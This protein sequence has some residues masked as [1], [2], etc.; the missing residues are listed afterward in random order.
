MAEPVIVPVQLEVT[1]LDM[2]NFNPKDVQKSISNA[3]SGVKKSIQDAFKGIDPS[4]INKPIESAMTS[5]SKSVQTAEEAYAR[6]NRTLVQAGKSTT[7]YKA[8]VGKI[9]SDISVWAKELSHVREHYDLTMRKIEATSDS[10]EKRRLVDIS[11]NDEATI[12]RIQGHISKLNAEITKIN[13]VDFVK[14]ADATQLEKVALAYQKVLSVTGEVNKKSGDFNQTV[15]DNQASDKYAEL[16]KQAE[17]YQQKLK[18]LSEKSKEMEFKGATDNQWENLRKETE[19][20]SK[21][22]DDVLKKMDKAIK[23]GE[24]FRFGEGSKKDLRNQYNS[25]AMSNRN[26]KYAKERSQNNQSPYT[27][28]YQKA[29]DD[30]DKLEQKVKSIKEKS[31]KMIELG[32]SKKEFASTAYD[33]NKLK[34]EVEAA[35]TRITDMVNEGK[36]FRFGKGDAA[37]EIN[38]VSQKSQGLEKELEDVASDSEKARR[39]LLKFKEA[40]PV[41]SKILKVAGGIGYGFA[42]VGQGV[43]TA[44]LALGK[45]VKNM[46][47][48][49]KAG[50]RT[51]GDLGKKF[52]KLSRNIMMFGLGFR[53]AYYAVK[54]LRNIFVEGFKAMGEQFGEIGTPMTAMMESFD[55]LKGSLATVLQPIA[56]ILMPLI[57]TLMNS[58]TGVMEKIAEFTAVLSGQ[59]YIYK[60]VAKDINSV[61]DA[62]KNANKQL[63][64]Y[65]KLEV[66]SDNKSGQE[67][68]QMAVGDA[69]TASSNFAKMVK[70]AWEKADFTSV[71]A[72]I[73]KKLAEVLNSAA[74]NMVPK[75]MEFANKILTSIN[76]F[77]LG[78]DATSVGSA[79]SNILNA[80][81]TGLDWSQL[82]SLF[83][84]WTNTVWGFLDGLVNGINWSVLGQSIN[85]GL[86]S[87]VD[88]LDFD[89]IADT[90]SGLVMGLIDVI[91]SIDWNYIANKLFTGV[92]KILGTVG[93]KM[94]TSNNPMVS[95][96]GGVVLALGEAFNNLKP[97]IETIIQAFGPIITAILPVISA[98][99]P[100]ISAIIGTLVTDLLPPIV[101]LIEAVMPLLVNIIEIIM[102]VIQREM[103]KITSVIGIVIDIITVLVGAINLV[104][105]TANVLTKVF[106]GEF[107]SFKDIWDALLDAWRPAINSILA[108]VEGMVNGVITALNKMIGGLNKVSFDI[109]DWGIFGD[110]AG[111][112]FGLNIGTI[113]K[114][115]I[116][117][118]AQGA[119]IP[120]NQEFLAVLGDQK[121]G[122]NIEAPLDTIKQA[123][124]EVLAETRGDSKDPIVL[125]LNG[126]DIAKVVWDEEEKRYKQTGRYATI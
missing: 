1:D 125:R 98:L 59:K 53:T 26:S 90:I 67:Y 2:S 65:D 6:Y 87:L 106:R 49:G 34:S 12:Q 35:K 7:E 105:G 63:A 43:G 48:F 80:V 4:A 41:L 116:P 47:L 62:S 123:L 31:A 75:A 103:S 23:S 92:M 122:T 50:S 51:S 85:T 74:T 28:D 55:R 30:L 36:A 45:G 17:G 115:S 100:P 27:A 113:G 54:R 32:A 33:A 99:L 10:T 64:S 18:D 3:L 95:A 114:V 84:N 71:G 61:A 72:F 58:L 117:R 16:V 24:A 104:M 82:G 13:P 88:N 21:Q 96:F 9:R 120:P 29:L 119:V 60:A 44:A 39:K 78:F 76:T 56:S 77:L 93:T 57:T 20:T 37:G 15:K 11:K 14:D 38:K 101:R 79:M 86:K 25:F 109:P 112:K 70:D 118:L 8:K 68:T 40:H 22:M 89:K 66:I 5:V 42:K 81:V 107:D 110:L 102:P 73:S 91:T 46:G 121:R 94:S 97:A 19:W 111:K 108:G 83:A 69:E 126:R 124:A 52:K